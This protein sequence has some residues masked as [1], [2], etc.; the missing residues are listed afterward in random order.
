M[1]RVSQGAQ[2][3]AWHDLL[4][5]H[6][7]GRLVGCGGFFLDNLVG[8]SIDA[9]ASGADLA[10]LNHGKLSAKQIAG[11]LRDL[12]KLPPLPEM[13][14]RV[15]L[16]ERFMFLDCV[17]ILD[18]YGIK[19]LE[20]LAD[21]ESSKEPHP[22][23]KLL[24]EKVDWDPALR[25]ANR[26]YDRLVAAMSDPD[27]GSRKK[28]LATIEADVKA[29]HKRAVNPQALTE[30]FLAKK[31]SAKRRGK[32]IGDLLLALM[33]PAIA[34]LQK[35]ADQATQRQDNLT[36]AFALARYQR[37]HGRYPRKLAVLAPKY[38]KK[39]P[40]DLFSGKVLV[41]RPSAK[42]YL[43]YSVGPD[44]KDDDGRGTHDDP[45]GDDLSVRMP[46]PRLGGN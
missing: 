45:P 13:A 18:R 46:L 8:L 15:N 1:L 20:M 26:W 21:R 2:E 10:F 19:G 30:A 44:G 29:L 33:L 34:K 32:A 9:I 6:R 12:Q 14:D 11:C 24:L 27:P 31:E 42:G 3:E 5:C 23:A 25:N 22:L 4:A 37:E 40:H 43:L 39:I 41:Y 28:K 35:A 36:L 38:L 16:G 7:L 17:L